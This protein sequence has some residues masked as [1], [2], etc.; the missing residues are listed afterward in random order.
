MLIVT[1]YEGLGTKLDRDEDSEAEAIS[2]YECRALLRRCID[3]MENDWW[4]LVRY[5]RSQHG[6]D[7]FT[8]QLYRNF[9]GEFREA[10]ADVSRVECQIRDHLQLEAGKLGLEESRKSI[11]MSNRQIEEAKRGKP[12]FSLAWIVY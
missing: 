3:D 9:E 11:E 5:I 6:T 1:G 8:G 2:L 4:S 7:W 10:V 12:K